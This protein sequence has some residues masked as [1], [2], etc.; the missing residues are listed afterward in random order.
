[1][2]EQERK[3]IDA[4]NILCEFAD[5]NLPAGWE[6]QLSMAR[7]EATMELYDPS[8][9]EITT[10]AADYG[11]STL[12]EMCSMANAIEKERPFDAATPSEGAS[13]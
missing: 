5:K 9:A 11:T 3:L 10:D 13:S 7:G 8:G 1:M 4:T 6:I 12:S 2:N